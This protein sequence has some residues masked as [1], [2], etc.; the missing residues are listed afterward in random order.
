MTN[1]K[2]IGA[3][4]DN[5]SIKCTTWDGKNIVYVITPVNPSDSEKE[6]T[7]DFILNELDGHNEVKQ[8]IR[9]TKISLEWYEKGLRAHAQITGKAA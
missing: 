6:E 1:Y 2:K 5:H 4:K 9:L 7:I 3:S 8:Y